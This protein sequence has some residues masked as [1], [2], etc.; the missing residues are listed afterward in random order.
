MAAVEQGNTVSKNV[1]QRILL[2]AVAAAAALVV[3]ACGGDPAPGPAGGTTGGGSGPNGQNGAITI[4]LT[5]SSGQ[6]SNALSVSSPLNVTAVVRDTAGRPVANTVV[7]F[8]IAA[9][10]SGG[11]SGGGTTTPLATF[12]PASGNGITDANGTVTIG[13][14]AGGPAAQGA[15]TLNASA[16]G[17]GVGPNN[18]LTGSTAFQVAQSSISLTNLTLTPSTIDAFQTSTVAVTVAGVPTTTPVTVNFT[19]VCASATPPKATLTPSAVTVNGVATANYADKGCGQ[20]DTITAS[21]AG[22]PSVQGSLTIRPAAATNLVFV[23][24]NPDVIGIQGSGANTSS[25]VSFK[26]V[27]AAQQPVPNISV[28]MTLDTSV[29]GVALENGQATQTKTTAADGTVSTQVVAG[30]QPTPVRV[31][32][33]TT[34]GLSAVSSNLTIQSGLPTQARFSLS[35]ETFNIE[36]W[37]RDGQQTGVTIRA[38]DRVGNPVPDGT[39][40]NFRTS[41]AAIQPSCSTVG[42]VCSVQFTSQANRPAGGRV[43]VLAY[44]S[45]LE[46]FTDLNGNNRYDAGE[47]FEDLGDAFVDANFNNTWDSGEDFIPF[48]PNATSACTNVLGTPPPPMRPNTCDGV[49]GA[50]QVRAQGVVTLSSSSPGS[51][52]YSPASPLRIASAALATCTGSF[53][54]LLADVNN[55]PMPA[56]TKIVATATGVAATVA[57]DSVVNTAATGPTTHRV[58]VSATSCTGGLVGTVSLKVTT[59]GGLTTILPDMTILY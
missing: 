21:A 34:S 20:T 5:N 49:W 22:A 14:V 35:I 38:A 54:I 8:S 27:D 10:G 51:V 18:T 52:T 55:N 53:D 37:N 30:T 40:V 23:S 44:A 31:R 17:N 48:N 4:T 28:T 36:G 24:A 46:S 56:G 3:A 50:A 59:P 58:Q 7:Q 6:P 57:N 43:R 2:G 16:T 11:G 33:T 19:S 29:G 26:V 47:P 39:R 45:G 9:S 15:G 12:S 1:L 32:A 41:G 13:L 25:V 42:G